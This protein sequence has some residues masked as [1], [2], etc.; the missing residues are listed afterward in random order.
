MNLRFRVDFKVSI[1][2][3]VNF[4]SLG[5]SNFIAS[6]DQI[7]TKDTFCEIMPNANSLNITS[8][9]ESVSAAYFKW[10]FVMY[11]LNALTD[12]V[13]QTPTVFGQGHIWYFG[14]SPSQSTEE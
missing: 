14:P 5:A 3:R 9:K 11:E 6:V 2:V 13:S 4:H 1:Y 12:F 8:S 10:H 7:Q